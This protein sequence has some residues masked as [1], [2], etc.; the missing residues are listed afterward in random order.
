MIFVRRE[1]WGPFGN[2]LA[3]GVGLIFLVSGINETLRINAYRI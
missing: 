2:I 3:S 1:S